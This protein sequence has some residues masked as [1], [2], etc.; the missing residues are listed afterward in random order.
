METEITINNSGEGSMN[1]FVRIT[2]TLE[3]TNYFP[4]VNVTIK[5]PVVSVYSINDK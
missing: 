1:R 3:R 4:R 5:I 2:G